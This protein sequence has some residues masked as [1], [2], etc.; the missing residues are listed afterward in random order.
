MINA[1][2]IIF[3]GTIRDNR[4]VL[5]VMYHNKPLA[6]KLCRAC[7]NVTVRHMFSLRCGAHAEQGAIDSWEVIASKAVNIGSSLGLATF[8]YALGRSFVAKYLF[9]RTFLDNKMANV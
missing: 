5:M 9:K 2:R 6:S 8:G 3:D 7:I 1:Y 4:E